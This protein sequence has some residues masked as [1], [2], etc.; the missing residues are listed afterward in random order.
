MPPNLVPAS[1]ESDSPSHIP[2][3]IS[4]ENAL[5]EGECPPKVLLDQGFRVLIHVHKVKKYPPLDALL[6]V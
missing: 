3:H 6:L 1:E 5:I 2:S 4:G